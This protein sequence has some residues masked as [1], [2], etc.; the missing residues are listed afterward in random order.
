MLVNR[1]QYHSPGQQARTGNFRLAG[2]FVGNIHQMYFRLPY[3][4]NIPILQAIKPADLLA[5]DIGAIRAFQVLDH[6]H[7]GDRIKQISA[8]RREAATSLTTI[9]L[10]TMRPMVIFPEAEFNLERLT[11]GAGNG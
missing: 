11:L 10:V 3:A 7:F 5:V 4:N 1:F 6:Q 9:S 8:C 2:D